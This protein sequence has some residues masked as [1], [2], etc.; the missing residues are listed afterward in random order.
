[1]AIIGLV[2]QKG[3]AGK[4]TAAIALG[5]ALAKRYRVALVDLDPQGS[6]GRWGTMATLPGSLEVF[7]ARKPADVRALQGFD[8]VIVDTKGELSAD[9]L[10][11][12][13]LALIPCSPSLF[14]LWAAEPTVEL[15]KAQQKARPGLRAAIFANRVREG[16]VLGAD[17]LEEIRGFGLPV[18][19]VH[20]GDRIAYPTSIA[21]GANPVSSGNSDA[22]LESL[23]FAAN[24]EKL[25]E[26]RA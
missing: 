23:R 19:D 7:Q 11:L 22:R 17:V 21:T 9:A 26:K 24:V 6:V 14:D 13:D 18:L 1:M 2:S 5:S 8:F 12:F 10:P 3:G 25:L 4:S 20:L 15:V 16:T